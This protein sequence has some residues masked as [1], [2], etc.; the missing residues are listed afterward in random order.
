VDWRRGQ[1][2][3]RYVHEFSEAELSDLARETGFR[4]LESFS[5]DGVDRRS[6]WYEIWT[7]G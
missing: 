1:S 7:P 4:A 3:V 2:G 6:G 5:S